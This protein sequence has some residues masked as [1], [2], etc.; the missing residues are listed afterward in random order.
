M[1][2][3][4]QQE[5]LQRLIAEAKASE[6]ALLVVRREAE[7]ERVKLEK[8]KNKPKIADRPHIATIVTSIVTVG[9]T[10]WALWFTHKSVTTS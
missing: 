8:A 9:L 10:L 7:E 5:E 2:P 4:E 3:R 6:D 1:D